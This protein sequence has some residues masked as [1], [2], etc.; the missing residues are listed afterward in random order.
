M[1]LLSTSHRMAIDFIYICSFLINS[2][3]TI[4]HV[5]SCLKPHVQLSTCPMGTQLDS[6]YLGSLLTKQCHFPPYAQT[7]L[8]S[9]IIFAVTTGGFH[10]SVTASSSPA[11]LTD[12]VPPIEVQGTSA[13]PI[14]QP[15]ATLCKT[16]HMESRSA[17]AELAAVT[18]MHT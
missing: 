2:N 9:I 12:T 1:P 10:G 11:Q 14:A 5:L 13:I 7:L 8:T 4:S 15:R 18:H 3:G 6:W 16:K 17:H